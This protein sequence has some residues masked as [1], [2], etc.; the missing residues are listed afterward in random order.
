MKTKN[1]KALSLVAAVAT[2]VAPAALAQGTVY[3]NTYVRGV[4][5]CHVYAPKPSAFCV[6]QVGNGTSD[7]PAGT[8]DWTGWTLIGANGPGGQ[9]GGTNTYAQV[10][11]AP[12]YNRPESALLPAPGV[13]IFR[14]NVAAGFVVPTTVTLQNVPVEAPAATLEIVAWDNSSGHYPTWTEASVAWEDGLIAAGRSGRWNQDKIGGINPPPFLINSVDPSQHLVSF[15]LSYKGFVW[16]QYQPT[17]QTV[18]AGQTATF[19]TYA[20]APGCSYQW[21][22]NGANLGSPIT[23]QQDG[24]CQFTIANAQLADEGSYSVVASNA[25]NSATSAVAVLTVNAL[26]VGLRAH[27]GSTVVKLACEPVNQRT[28]PLR[29]NK[30]GINYSIVLTPPSSPDASKFRVQTSSGVKALMKLP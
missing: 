10:L 29:I 15:A 12:G 16:F 7:Y 3:F 13:T 14:T 1:N 8:T 5:V 23:P 24:P 6:I 2:L 4:M 9:Y 30:N 26:D 20:D 28:S 25:C 17:N 11:A 21:R 22:L 19:W 27:D 18:L